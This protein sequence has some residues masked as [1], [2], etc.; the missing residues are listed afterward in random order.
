MGSLYRN[1]FVPGDDMM[2]TEE[3]KRRVVGGDDCDILLVLVA[4]VVMVKGWLFVRVGDC[5]IA[6]AG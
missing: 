2:M 6:V 3:L 1:R 4:T 5:C